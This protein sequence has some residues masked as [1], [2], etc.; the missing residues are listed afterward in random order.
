MFSKF[1][2]K[3][4]SNGQLADYFKK[5]KRDSGQPNLSCVNILKHIASN[6]NSPALSKQGRHERK[7]SPGGLVKQAAVKSARPSTSKNSIKKINRIDRTQVPSRDKTR[8]LEKPKQEST[9]RSPKINKPAFQEFFSARGL[10]RVTQVTS[11]LKRTRDLKP[12]VSKEP[13]KLADDSLKARSTSKKHEKSQ[14]NTSLSSRIPKAFTPISN[15]SK[16]VSRENSQKQK[17]LADTVNSLTKKTVSDIG[18]LMDKEKKRQTINSQFIAAAKRNEAEKCLQLISGAP[19]LGQN[20]DINCQDK[21]GWTAVHHACWNENLKLVN[22]L[23]YNDARLDITDAGGIRP[24][25]LAVSKGNASI[26]KVAHPL[27]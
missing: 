13:P 18:K 8:E 14:T 26:T 6:S 22:I 10:P 5:K 1:F 21:E 23:L 17:K 27:N 4:K 3:N 2:E 24:L 9:S 11:A 7:T 20:A 15:T 19:S 16:K 12:L 25:S